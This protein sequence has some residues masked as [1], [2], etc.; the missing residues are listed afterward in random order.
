MN[1]GCIKNLK[2]NKKGMKKSSLVLT[3][4]LVWLLMSC[5]VSDLRKDTDLEGINSST[6]EI[7][8]KGKEIL[9]TYVSENGYEK[10]S[11]IESY[12]VDV[13]E[14]WQGLMGMMGN[15]WP[16]KDIIF[17][18]ELIPDKNDFVGHYTLN[19]GKKNGTSWGFAPKYP[20]L[21]IQKEGNPTKQIKKRKMS[22]NLAN[23]Q[24]WMEYPFRMA[25]LENVNYAGERIK[26]GKAYN[27]ILITWEKI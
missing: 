19:S 22:F 12:K 8:D 20:S 24:W 4:S 13:T 5:K 10:F 26:D 11:G 17:N 23:Y 3:L 6:K 14:N 9:D 25:E 16:E 15:P 2:Q 7:Q 18:M 21:Y 27:L 1:F